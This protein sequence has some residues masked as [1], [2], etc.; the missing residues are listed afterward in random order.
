MK[1]SIEQISDYCHCPL[2]YYLRWVDSS[3]HEDAITVLEK[4]DREL[5]KTIY[6]FYSLIQNHE[7]AN[8]S[9]LKRAWGASWIGKK[10]ASEII[11]SNSTSW[12]DTHEQ[13]RR[14]GIEAIV[15]FYDK[16][17]DNPGYPIAINAPYELKLSKGLIVTGK[18]E[19]I[20]EVLLDN[21][22]HEIQLVQFKVDD[23]VHHQVRMEHDLSVSAGQLA[24][25]QAFNL[26]ANRI[27]TYGFEKGKIHE[28]SRSEGQLSFFEHTAYC[29]ARGIKNRLFYASPSSACDTCFYRT[30]C[31]QRLNDDKFIQ[32]LIKGE[33]SC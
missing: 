6:S 22:K 29:V 9:A 1:I 2:Y 27:I 19:L 26:K 14:R 18:W 15:R 23:K 24:F 8:L 4:Y 7:Q 12:R 33:T 20:R 5:H 21:G 10:Q 31:K 32:R 28:L 25:E 3:P 30:R 11:I 17:K 13:R 16:F